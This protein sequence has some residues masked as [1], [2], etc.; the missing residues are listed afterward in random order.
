L[1]LNL[2][3]FFTSFDLF[4]AFAELNTRFDAL[5]GGWMNVG[6]EGPDG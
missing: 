5:Q 6:R 3:E 2:F 4:R 1:I